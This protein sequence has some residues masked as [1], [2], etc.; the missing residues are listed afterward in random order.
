MRVTV[1]LTTGEDVDLDLGPAELVELR[2]TVDASHPRSFT[3]LMWRR[4]GSSIPAAEATIVT[5]CIA[6]IVRHGTTTAA[7]G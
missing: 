1:H 5:G 6:K 3:G 2:R 7:D 4:K